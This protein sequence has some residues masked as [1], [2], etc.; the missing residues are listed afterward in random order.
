MGM[1]HGYGWDHRFHCEKCPN[2]IEIEYQVWEYPPG[3]FNNDDA[4]N[5]TGGEITSKFDYDFQGD[6]E[7]DLW[8]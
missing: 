8:T 6:I 7:E 4:T 5:I 1:E 3:A 2:Y